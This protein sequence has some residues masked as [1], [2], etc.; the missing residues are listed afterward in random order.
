MIENLLLELNQQQGTTLVLV[1]H[2]PALATRCQYQ[3]NMVAGVLQQQSLEVT[4][5]A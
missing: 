4:D 2:N 3:L 1:T 5:V